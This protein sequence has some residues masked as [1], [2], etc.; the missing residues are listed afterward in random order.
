[1]DENK[2]TYYDKDRKSYVFEEIMTFHVDEIGK[3]F[4]AYT[5]NDDNVSENVDVNLVEILNM[6][7]DKPTFK[8]IDD[9]DMNM[10]IEVFNN[11]LEQ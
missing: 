7:S 10:V 6:D 8:K 5:V 2:R 1:M 9:E 11:L 4:L 3:T